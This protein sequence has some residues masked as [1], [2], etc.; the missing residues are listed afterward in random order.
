MHREIVESGL[1]EEVNKLV[2]LILDRTSSVADAEHARH[3]IEIFVA[4]YRSAET[5]M[6]Q[7]FTTN[8]LLNCVDDLTGC[9]KRLPA[10][11]M[12]GM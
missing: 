6:V 9:R 10:S 1:Y 12:S 11:S 7:E 2:L 5:G 3:V 4:V 8:F